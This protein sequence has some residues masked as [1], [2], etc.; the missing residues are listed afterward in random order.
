MVVLTGLAKYS[1]SFLRVS[2]GPL[3]PQ[4][5]IQWVPHAWDT[6]MCLLF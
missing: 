4:H 1:A 5:I 2:L 3:D 6:E